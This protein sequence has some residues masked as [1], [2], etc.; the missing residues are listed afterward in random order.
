MHDH[1][2]EAVTD[3][4]AI[5]IHMRFSDALAEL[6]GYPGAQ[7]HRS[8]WVAKSAVARVTRQG[9]KLVIETRAGRRLPVSKSHEAE[10]RADAG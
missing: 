4:G 7:V 9:R 5:L 10:W 2:V 3:R 6:A 1:Y 8:Y